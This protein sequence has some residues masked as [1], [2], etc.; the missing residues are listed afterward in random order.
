M[1]KL[2]GLV[3]LSGLLLAACA[4]TPLTPE[5]IAVESRAYMTRNSLERGVVTTPS[6]LQ[7][8]VVR[9]VGAEQPRP[10]A[11]DIVIVH[12]EGRFP[13]S[14]R[15]DKRGEVFDSSYERGEPAEFPLNRVIR[16]WTEGVGLMRLGEE[17][18]LYIPPE[19]A[20]G[21]RGAGADIPP[22]QALVFKVELLGIKRADGTELMAPPRD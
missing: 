11:T 3:L 12:Y 8:R 2:R 4:T 5:E 18:M 10:Q 21:E 22:N 1:G 14:G 19:L 6:G 17:Y 7:Y 16:G 13:S 9:A 15:F 20:Y